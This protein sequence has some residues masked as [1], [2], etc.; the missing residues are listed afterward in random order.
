LGGADSGCVGS[1]KAQNC[2]N[3]RVETRGG[4]PQKIQG[5]GRGEKIGM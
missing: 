1:Q 2:P 5:L 4:T 3:D